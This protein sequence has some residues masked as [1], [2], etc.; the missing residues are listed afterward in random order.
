MTS[1]NGVVDICTYIVGIHNDILTSHN[2]FL[3]IQNYIVFHFGYLDHWSVSGSETLLLVNI[4]IVGF[5]YK[6]FIHL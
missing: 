4:S 5:V 2:V 3:D 6:S 1:K